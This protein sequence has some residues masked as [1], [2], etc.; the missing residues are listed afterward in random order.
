MGRKISITCGK[1]LVELSQPAVA[2][3]GYVA[4]HSL[5]DL[6]GAVRLNDRLFIA[7]E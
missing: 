3:K 7:L 1:V 4:S 6:L 2:K 5:F